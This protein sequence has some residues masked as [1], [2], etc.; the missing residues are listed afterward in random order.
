ML[1]EG[2]AVSQVIGDV[3]AL[4]KNVAVLQR[5]LV[6]EY[7]TLERSRP[8]SPNTDPW[9][10]DWPW[11][12]SIFFVFSSLKIKGVGQ[13]KRQLVHHGALNYSLCH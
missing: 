2:L 8:T 1:A 10:L 6:M 13:E 7:L 12:S 4:D 11:L 5:V 9:T 3:L